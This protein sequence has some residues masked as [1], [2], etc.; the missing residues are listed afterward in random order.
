MCELTYNIDTAA[1][2][3]NTTAARIAVAIRDN[4]L[5]AY[6]IDGQAMMLPDDIRAWVKS[7]PKF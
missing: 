4:Q 2:H 1:A 6:R 3:A 5:T 7:H